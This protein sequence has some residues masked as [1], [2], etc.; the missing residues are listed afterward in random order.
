MQIEAA[1]E[2]I[3]QRLDNDVLI[4]KDDIDLRIE[5]LKAGLD[6]LRDELYASVD[7]KKQ[8]VLK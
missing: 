2:Q 7:E 5:S 1:S 6:D 3:K 4:T 8:E